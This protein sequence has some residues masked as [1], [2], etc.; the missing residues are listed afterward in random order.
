MNLAVI[1]RPRPPK[2]NR[3]L[4]FVP[5]SW[6]YPYTQHRWRLMVV[7]GAANEYSPR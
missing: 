7:F 2:H 4:A 5:S 6:L 1:I 3:T